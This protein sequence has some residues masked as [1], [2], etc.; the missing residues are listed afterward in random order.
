MIRTL[1]HATIAAVAAI[2]LSACSTTPD[3]S[4]TATPAQSAWLLTPPNAPKLRVTLVRGMPVGEVT[5]LFGSPDKVR[6]RPDAVQEWTYK[7]RFHDGASI[8]TGSVGSENLTALQK[9]TYVETIRIRF[10]NDLL[11]TVT[12]TQKRERISSSVPY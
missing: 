5:R 6:T 4:S 12:T 3:S 11:A 1:R 2:A 10:E 9:V 8:T 7:R